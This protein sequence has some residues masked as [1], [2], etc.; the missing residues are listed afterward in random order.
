L[1]A[2]TPIAKRAPFAR[3]RC[4]TTLAHSKEVSSLSRS[5]I[6]VTKINAL[7]ANLR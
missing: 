6:D 1:G 2:F 4:A 7:R 3:H 5:P